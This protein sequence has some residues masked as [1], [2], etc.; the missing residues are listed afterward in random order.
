MEEKQC[1]KCKK[2][3]PLSE[4][5]YHK[6]GKLTGKPFPQCKACLNNTAHA[7]YHLKRASRTIKIKPKIHSKKYL[8]NKDCPSYLGVAVAEKVLSRFFNHIQR[9]PFNN[10]GYDFI[11]GKGYKI[12]V[13]AACLHYPK[14]TIT[15]NKYIKK[16]NPYWMFL[17]NRN[18]IADYFLLLAFSDRETLEPIHVWLIP[19]S[20]INMQTGL[21]ITN[22]PKALLKWQPYEKPLDKVIHCCNL[23][24][25][26][27]ETIYF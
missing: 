14:T 18:Q 16:Y 19:A 13:K 2:V 4:F 20:K 22:I 9:M 5:Y 15:D 7:D 24:R 17:L 12:D 3:K 27:E 1:S 6:T 21:T 10:S 8:K 26:T 23:L 25:D 11:C